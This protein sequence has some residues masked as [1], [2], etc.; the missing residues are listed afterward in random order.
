MEFKQKNSKS[1]VILIIIK[2]NEII[3]YKRITDSKATN[4]EF[5]LGK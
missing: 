1:K 5:L 2:K 3:A 4:Q